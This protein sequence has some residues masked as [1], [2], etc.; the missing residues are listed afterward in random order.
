M[1]SQNCDTCNLTNEWTYEWINRWSKKERKRLFICLFV[2]TWEKVVRK[3]G[4]EQYFKWMNELVSG[5]TNEQK[6]SF[7][8]SNCSSHYGEETASHTIFPSSLPS[9]CGFV[10]PCSA[11]E[12]RSASSYVI[13]S[14]VK[15][16]TLHIMKLFMKHVRACRSSSLPSISLL[17]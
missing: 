5:R 12:S 7:Y 13:C 8:L 10:S 4:Y 17:V 6:D 15:A 2:F 16:G 11:G 14:A 1:E 3:L 9:L